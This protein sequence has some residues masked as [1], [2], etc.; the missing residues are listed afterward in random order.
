MQNK[1]FIYEQIFYKKFS[2]LC[3]DI[4]DRLKK[5]PC[6]KIL[7]TCYSTPTACLYYYTAVLMGLFLRDKHFNTRKTV[8]N[9]LS[10]H[11]H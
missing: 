10:T 8:Y 6:I 11:P 9:L 2:D 5:F 3:F 7:L 4:F 1:N